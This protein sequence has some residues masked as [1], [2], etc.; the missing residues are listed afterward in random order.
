MLEYL[1]AFFI[2]L[3]G[4]NT[5]FSFAFSVPRISKTDDQL[6]PFCTQN[7]VFRLL[8]SIIFC[9]YGVFLMT[10]ELLVCIMIAELV[11]LLIFFVY[12]VCTKRN[13]LITKNKKI[14]ESKEQKIASFK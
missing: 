5:V 3:Y 2:S 13:F 14:K 12:F 1:L 9:L 7:Y 10:N 6:I 8:T 4:I 11:V